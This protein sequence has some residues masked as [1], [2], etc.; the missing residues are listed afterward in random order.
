MRNV[1][2]STYADMVLSVHTGCVNGKIA[3]SKPLYLIAIMEAIEFQV[4][5][6]NK[7]DLFNVFVR[8]RFGQLYEQVNGNKKGYE[9][10]F[11]FDRSF[12]L[13]VPCFII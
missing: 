9:I 10:S 11:L 2:L 13:T 12:I 3:V 1:L 8:K 6:E 4:L 7:I 5:N